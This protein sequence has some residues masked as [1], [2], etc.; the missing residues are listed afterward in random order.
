MRLNHPYFVVNLAASPKVLL[1]LLHV[2]SV[3]GTN[4]IIDEA[5]GLQ[6]FLGGKYP[7]CFIIR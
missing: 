3:L 6:N 4:H 2:A 7:T 1:L 5:L